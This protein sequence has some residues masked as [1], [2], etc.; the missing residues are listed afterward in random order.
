MPGKIPNW[1]RY[2]N[3]RVLNRLLG[4]IAGLPYSPI[5]M[6]YHTGRRSGKRY[7]TPV[8]VASVPGG[9]LFALTYGDQVDWY[10]NILSSGEAAVRWHGKEYA[11]EAPE[12]VMPEEARL[13]FPAP[14]RPILKAIGPEHYFWMRKK[15]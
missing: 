9:F 6:V 12:K 2:F 11:L 14:L 1:V 7:H 13:A 15:T 5:T 4:K 3:K 10:R 8:I